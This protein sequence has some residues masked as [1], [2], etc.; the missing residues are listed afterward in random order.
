MGIWQI[1]SKR[2]LT[3]GLITATVPKRKHSTGNNFLKVIIGENKTKVVRIKGGNVKVKA[4]AANT[5]NITDKKTGKTKN[6]GIEAVIENKANPHFIRQKLI[7]KGA[8]VKTSVGNVRIT[9]RPAQHGVVN[10]I[11]VE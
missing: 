1:K 11:V 3:G 2:K 6:V 8:I 7:T 4:V 10:G 9:S 5:V